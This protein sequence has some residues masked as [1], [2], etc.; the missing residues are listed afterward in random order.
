MLEYHFIRNIAEK[1]FYDE[2]KTSCLPNG[3]SAEEG[4]LKDIVK[5]SINSLITKLNEMEKGINLGFLLNTSEGYV[6]E[7][8]DLL[9][10]EI[11]KMKKCLE[12]LKQGLPDRGSVYV[13]I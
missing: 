4:I 10:R 12:R 6:R 7:E 8:A 3:S 9:Q 5:I 11:N 2:W 13:D 1:Y